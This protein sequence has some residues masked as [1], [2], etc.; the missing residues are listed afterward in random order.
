MTKEH[1]QNILCA[2]SERNCGSVA[3]SGLLT[4]GS[5][6]R[7]AFPIRVD[8]WHDNV[9]IVTGHSGGPV[10]DSHRLPAEDPQVPR[11]QQSAEAL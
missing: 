9:A 11:P 8:Q 4:S 3:Q 7:D 2:D 1:W 6:S 5:I 10:P